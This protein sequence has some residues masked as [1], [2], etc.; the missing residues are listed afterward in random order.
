VSGHE[1]APR[2]R[3][4]GQRGILEKD[5][6]NDL[7]AIGDAVPNLEKKDAQSLDSFIFCAF[8]SA[9]ICDICNGNK[10]SW[11]A[12]VFI[13]EEP[14]VNAKTARLYFRPRELCL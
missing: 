9:S 12:K 13:S 3:G 8:T 4:F 2:L 14:C 5:G 6:G 1:S 10:Q 7:K 11:L